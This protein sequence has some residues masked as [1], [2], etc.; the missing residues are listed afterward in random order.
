MIKTSYS[1]LAIAVVSCLIGWFS[2]EFVV[3]AAS[4]FVAVGSSFFAGIRYAKGD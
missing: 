1:F 2:D 3:S 4:Y